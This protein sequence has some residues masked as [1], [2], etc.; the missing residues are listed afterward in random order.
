MPPTLTGTPADLIQ[1]CRDLVRTKQCIP[2]GRV[3][4]I[5][6]GP[7]GDYTPPENDP[8]IQKW[9][10]L[11][12]FG[13]DRMLPIAESLDHSILLAM[14]PMVQRDG[15]VGLPDW[16]DPNWKPEPWT[17]EES[18]GHYEHG[19]YVERTARDPL[20]DRRPMIPQRIQDRA[21]TRDGRLGVV[22]G[23]NFLVFQ[24]VLRM[25]FQPE[26]DGALQGK[27][28]QIDC[29]FSPQDSRHMTLLVDQKTGET[30]FFG[31]QYEVNF[32]GD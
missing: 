6:I 15:T 16:P 17:A 12:Q 10:R 11:M 30:I 23:T 9:G 2:L 22:E 5:A 25:V 26:K 20:K 21:E 7:S 13:S 18:Q 8:L 4:Q 1:F 14:A 28:G 3:K 32:I 29:H 24:P 19:K 31:G 27:T